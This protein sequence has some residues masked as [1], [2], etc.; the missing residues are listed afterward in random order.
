MGQFGE[1]QYFDD[2]TNSD[3]PFNF[4]DEINSYFGTEFKTSDFDLMGGTIE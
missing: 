3:H 1:T 4:L 2:S